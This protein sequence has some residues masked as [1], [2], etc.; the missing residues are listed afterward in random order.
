MAPRSPV[1]V[2]PLR[3]RREQFVNYCY[4]LVH[5][6]SRD[7]VLIDPAWEPALID[8]TLGALGA[9]PRAVL[10][11]HHH[12]DH[13]D[14]ADHYGSRGLDVYM[15]ALEADFYG[16]HCAGLRRIQREQM[17]HLGAIQVNPLR[18]P[19]HTVGSIC[20]LASDALFTGDTVFA[21]GCGICSGRG[22]DP[23]EMFDSLEGLKRQL[24]PDIRVY[25]GHRYGLPP[26]QTWKTLLSCNLYLQF[27]RRDLFVEFRM[28]HGQQALMAFR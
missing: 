14:L 4:L 25:P 2:V 3:L 7:A 10:L 17:L 19:G 26:G 28:R 12:H 5:R 11:T 13:I 24:D 15:S 16:F 6:T 22:A 18:T 8:A 9:H 27:S 23:S 20:Y 1:E 21:E